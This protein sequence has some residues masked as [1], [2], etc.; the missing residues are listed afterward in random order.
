MEKS[1]QGVKKAKG[2]HQQYG[3]R[4]QVIYFIGVRYSTWYGHQY[5]DDP[6]QDALTFRFYTTAKKLKQEVN[7][8]LREPHII[9]VVDGHFTMQQL[10]D[11]FGHESKPYPGEPTHETEVMRQ[12]QNYLHGESALTKAQL[13]KKIGGLLS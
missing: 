11:Q 4:D 3:G 7:A 2:I 10:L 12:V 6:A 9:A 5:S 1:E 13:M 8:G